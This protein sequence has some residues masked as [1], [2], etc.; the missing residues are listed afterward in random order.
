MSASDPFASHGSLALARL[1]SHP[2]FLQGLGRVRDLE[3]L[4]ALLDAVGARPVDTHGSSDCSQWTWLA[5]PQPPSS[6]P[7]GTVSPLIETP[8]EIRPEP[9]SDSPVA[10]VNAKTKTKT[11]DL[12]GRLHGPIGA[13]RHRTLTVMTAFHRLGRL[14]VAEL[15]IELAGSLVLLASHVVNRMVAG[16]VGLLRLGAFLIEEFWWVAVVGL[17]MFL[18]VQAT[19]FAQTGLD[20]D[21]DVNHT[22]NPAL[23]ADTLKPAAG[24]K[25]YT[26]PPGFRPLAGSAALPAADV[27]SATAQDTKLYTTGEFYRITRDDGVVKALLLLQHTEAKSV[28][29]TIME[30]NIHIVFKPLVTMGKQYKQADALSWVFDN[31]EQMIFIDSMH[32][33]APPQAIAA[34]L[35]HEVLHDDD[36]NSIT[37]ELVAWR[38]ELRVWRMMKHMYPAL[39][40]IQ[41]KQYPLVDRLNA[42]IV[43]DDRHTL[44]ETI[45]SN[46]GYSHLPP[47]SPGF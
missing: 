43:L 29:Y 30:D 35:A 18:A 39:K 8:S 36:V 23:F 44:D 31:G 37:E 20:M 1:Y 11:K 7:V 34:I 19:A 32:H 38:Q 16:V 5:M 33:N 24:P 4:D 40:T 14:T 6:V 13:M 15:L 45:R 28:V 46:K 26:P 47:H 3:D 17:L 10:E 41:P 9:I 2:A 42:M 25:P 21:G 27:A 12:G 22:Y